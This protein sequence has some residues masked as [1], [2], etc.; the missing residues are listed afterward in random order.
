MSYWQ[1][2]I[3]LALMSEKILILGGTKEA[4]ELA[5]KLIDQGHDVTTSLAGRTREPKPVSGQ[6][7]TGGFGGAEGLA[8]YLIKGRFTKLIDATHPFAKQISVNAIEAAK[9]GNIKLEIHTRPSWE[10]QK[11][12]SWIEVT[13]L[14]EACESIPENARVLL[15][16]GSQY[17]DLF[18]TR[19]D[20]FFL[21]RMV[22]QPQAPLPLPN[23][24]LLIGKPSLDW[25]EEKAMLER[26]SITHI[27]CRNSGGTGAYA[28]IKAARELGMQVIIIGR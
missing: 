2:L 8:D 4:V 14:Q 20:V 18:Q 16:L 23:H 7:R 11:G 12:D 21:V 5:T 6:L 1:E 13:S 10:K 25:R 9:L 22:D 17:I 3:G 26:H 19:G 24:Q 28:K 27:V 15:A